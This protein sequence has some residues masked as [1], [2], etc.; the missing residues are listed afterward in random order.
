M[1]DNI[2]ESDCD[3]CEHAYYG[4]PNC[5]GNEFEINC[6]VF[7]FYINFYAIAACECN[8]EGSDEE[9]C[10]DNGR[11]TCKGPNIAGDKC[12]QCAPGKVPNSSLWVL[13]DVIKLLEILSTV[14]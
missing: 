4:F 2:I 3:S 8:A 13:G 12:D 7:Q 6:L 1:K 5:Q 10:H 14:M 9:Q 11:C